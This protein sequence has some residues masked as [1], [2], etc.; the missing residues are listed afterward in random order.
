[1]QLMIGGRVFSTVS[2]SLWQI[3]HTERENL[4]KGLGFLRLIHPFYSL[5]SSLAFF[6]LSLCHLDGQIWDESVESVC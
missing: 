1:M 5:L 6:L 2:L 4:Q 3:S